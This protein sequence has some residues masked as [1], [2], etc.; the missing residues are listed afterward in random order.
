MRKFYLFLLITL[1]AFSQ[2]QLSAELRWEPVDGWEIVGDTSKMFIGDPDEFEEVRDLMNTA[3]DAQERGKAKKAIRYYRRV[4]DRHPGSIF[5]PESLHQTAIVQHEISSYRKAFDTL[6]TVILGYPDYER[7]NE[8]V[9]RQ[10]AIASDLAEGK[11]TRYFG[12][13]I[14]GFKGYDRAVRMYETMISNAPYSEYAPVA[15][16]RAAE[17]Y[18]KLKK[19]PYALDALDRLINNYSESMHVGDAYLMLAQTFSRLVD[20]PEYDQGATREAISYYEDFLI[21][22]PD[23]AKVKDGEDGLSAMKSIEAQ[24]KMVK[25]DFYYYKWRDYGAAKIFYNEAITVAPNSPEA[26]IAQQQL[27]KITEIVLEKILEV[28][29]NSMLPN[30]QAEGAKAKK[31][32]VDL[33]K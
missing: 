7:Y 5:A 25:A 23:H 20:G 11:R 14:P 2:Q 32:N 18:I 10:F 24:S 31:E 1:Y 6:S 27:D 26:V 4:W 21:L 17:M 33:D 30:S 9:R 19:D 8:V 12:G 29:K 3:R 15:L 13:L 28:R 16:M 22:F